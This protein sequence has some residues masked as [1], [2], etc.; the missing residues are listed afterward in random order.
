MLIIEFSK[1]ILNGGFGDRIVGLISLKTV[2]KFLNTNFSNI[3][4]YKFTAT[5]ENDFD[6]ISNGSKQWEHIVDKIY[7]SFMPNITHLSKTG[8][9]K[10]KYSRII[11]IDP[12]TK[13]EICTYIAKYGP[14]VQLKNTKDLNKSKF[15]PLKDIK[16]EDVTLEQALKLLKYPYNFCKIDGKNV[17]ICNGQYGVYIKYNKRNVSLNGLSE[18]DLTE[19][20][21]SNLIKGKQG[22]RP[23]NNSLDNKTIKINKDIV[24]KTGKYGPYI[25]YKEKT[26]VKIYSKKKLEELTLEDCQVMIKK[27]FDY[28]KT[29]K[30][31]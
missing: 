7:K 4:D 20:I 6:E 3:L 22:D 1:D 13:F 31:K 16:M 29:N 19:S 23:N 14:V 18:N 17:E 26:N 21:I 27:Y 25:N 24:I 15:A 11:G 28:K 5:L 8:L 30:N 10:N 9:E 12:K 2:S